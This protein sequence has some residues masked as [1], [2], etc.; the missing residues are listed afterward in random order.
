MRPAENIERLIKN[1][2]DKTSANMDQRVRKNML[3]A[4]AESEKPS[5]LMWPNI[6]RTIMKSP[7]TKLV[8]AAAII[9]AV[10][11]GIHFSSGSF[12]GSTVAWGEVVRN[13]E[14]TH[15]IQYRETIT[16]SEEKTTI[17]YMSPEYGVKEECYKNGEIHSIACYQQPE[18]ML[19]AVLPLAKAYEH[20]P[21]TERELRIVR[22][23]RDGG[24]YVRKF[25]SAEYKQLG[26]TNINGVEVEGIEI[27]INSAELFE[28][29][30]PVD[31][32]VGRL[33]VDVA[34]DLPVLVELEFVPTGSSVQ[35]K[36]VTDQI[37]WN[38]ELS[39]S[40]YDLD[41]PADYE[42]LFKP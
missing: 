27:N 2:S 14:K 32:F 24:G 17:V 1:L 3:H 20:R 13:V 39:K 38:V 8:A 16:G 30:P 19:V 40:D 23:K 4:L 36:V 25:M 28:S 7:I 42:P 22:T 10:L 18:K 33:W 41:I 15:T 34:S 6:R 29:I 11:A 9:A 35:T 5:A 26:R 21:L 37:R 31:S 12:D